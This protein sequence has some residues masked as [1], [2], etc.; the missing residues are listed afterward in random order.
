VSPTP[1]VVVA[2]AG[3]DDPPPGIDAAAADV[4]LHYAPTAASLI[5][6]L[7]GADGLFLWGAERAWLE[8][9]WGHADRLRWI[10]SPSDGVDWFLFPELVEGP[11]EV[12]NA[13]GVYE[14]AIAE[15][16]V[17][18]LL[19]FATRILDQRDAQ[20]RDE[21]LSGDTMRL[22]GRRL[23]VVGPGP[24]GRAV[25]WR[26]EALGM[27]V[28]AAG[29]SERHDE[30]FGSVIATEDDDALTRALGEADVVLDALPFTP[31]TER[32]F[33]AGRFAAMRPTT[34]FLNVGRGATVDEAALIVSLQAG[35][36][37]AAAL[38]VFDIE[39]LP[40]ESPL[41]TMPNV[42]V[43][44]HMCGRFAGWQEATVAVFVDNAGRFARG[45][46]LRNPVDKHAGHGA[47]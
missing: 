26:A 30:L 28:A 2:G 3:E 24:I 33:D 5:E 9:A 35:G 20:M 42:L 22:T 10:H 23:L 41:W 19:A 13:R 38:D 14:D 32:F 31:A 43:S 45:E 4:S 11:V 29:R 37:G 44:P 8:D 17:G 18:A 40:P 1:V 21:W 27:T 12:T 47:S 25:G 39:P 7:P 36:I 6:E 34:W 46:P 15:W 16:V